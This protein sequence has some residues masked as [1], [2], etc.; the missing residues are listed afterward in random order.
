MIAIQA[1]SA[2]ASTVS[3]GEQNLNVMFTQ[4]SSNQNINLNKNNFQVLSQ[5]DVSDFD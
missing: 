1:M 4:G 2:F 5:F 3:F